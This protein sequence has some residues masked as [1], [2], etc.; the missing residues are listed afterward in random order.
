MTGETRRIGVL[1]PRG[2]VVHEREVE[3]LWP[4]G[5]SIR[6]LPF[7]YPIGASDFC[8]SLGDSLVTPLADLRRWG[9]EAVLVGCTTASM[10]CAG[11]GFDARLGELAGAPVITAARA[12]S[13][14]AMALGVGRLAVAS[15]YGEPNNKIVLDFLRREGFEIAALEALGLDADLDVWRAKAIPM[16]AE[17]VLAL[18]V[19]ADCEGA[20][21]V[22]LPCTGVGSLDAIAMFEQRT[23]KPAFSSVQAGFWATLRTAGIDGRQD[24]TGRLIREWPLPAEH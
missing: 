9:A 2:N 18:C 3:R 21:A 20:D 14:A 7:D 17:D 11:P 15:P 4:E 16:P 13:L 19:A 5:V 23:G 10:M 22:Y 24:G 6:V 1:V 12:S 8:A